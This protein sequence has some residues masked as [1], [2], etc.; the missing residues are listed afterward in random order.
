M[1]N[2]GRRRDRHDATEHVVEQVCGVCVRRRR[3]LGKIDHRE[4]RFGIG[5]RTTR[6][7]PVACKKRGWVLR[8]QLL[9]SH[10]FAAV[11]VEPLQH[12]VRLVGC[13]VII[14]QATMTIT[15]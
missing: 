4:R 15:G 10:E 14:G 6:F 12:I 5:M 9:Q 3:C 13:A 8:D 11:R 7:E 2:E 1:S